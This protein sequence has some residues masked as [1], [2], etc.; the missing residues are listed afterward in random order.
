M[1]AGKRQEATPGRPSRRVLVLDG[2]QASSLAI[3][4]SL[5]RR[6]LRVDAG[7]RK[8]S[9]LASYSRFLNE[10][11]T[12]P[13]PLADPAE[14]VRAIEARVQEIEYN[15][16]IPVTEDTVQPL[17]LARERIEAHTKLA[18][19]PKNALEIMTDKAK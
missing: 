9:F 2:N 5:G 16:V 6:G 13:D 1:P 15:L 3:V 4:R 17:A 12:Y 19:A 14:F 18:I 11:L 7:E 10:A 8:S